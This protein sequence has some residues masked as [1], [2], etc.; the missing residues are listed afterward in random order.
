MDGLAPLHE[1]RVI[2]CE[3][4]RRRLLVNLQPDASRRPRMRPQS[5]D[6]VWEPFVEGK[7]AEARIV[8]RERGKLRAL[9]SVKLS[10]N[11]GVTPP[12][13]RNDRRRQ[14]ICGN[15]PPHPG[16]EGAPRVL[17]LLRC[18]LPPT[19][20]HALGAAGRREGRSEQLRGD[21]VVPER[22]RRRDVERVSIVMVPQPASLRSAAVADARP[23]TRVPFRPSGGATR[24]RPC[25]CATQAGPA[26]S[27]GCAGRA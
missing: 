11:L 14:L 24:P 21:F 4:P 18:H 16:R 9:Q 22:T 25:A 7:R 20:G 2:A 8:R 27:D 15:Q 3:D 23:P 5:F 10:H 13:I 1:G 17:R 12:A 6:G 26:G 19:P